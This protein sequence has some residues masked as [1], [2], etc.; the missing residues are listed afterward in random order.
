[1]NNDLS[2]KGDI[3]AS[4]NISASGDFQTNDITASGDIS[5]SGDII[6]EKIGIGTSTP[7]KAI[8]ISPASEQAYREGIRIAQEK[9]DTKLA[10]KF[11]DK[12]IKSQLG[13]HTP[14]H[15]GN[16]FG[17]SSIRKMAIEFSPENENTAYYTHG[18]IQLNSFQNYEFVPS[19]PVD[20]NGI[21]LYFSFLPGLF[22]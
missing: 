7:D 8:E 15:Y 1:M 14:R 16:Y 9:N 21:N 2:V 17:A 22:D 18:G 13:G 3:S 6:T 10:Q 5:A 20:M 4:G 12:Y 11:C 19:S